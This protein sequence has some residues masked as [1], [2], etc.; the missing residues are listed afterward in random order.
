[1]NNKLFDKRITVSLIMQFIENMYAVTTLCEQPFVFHLI[2]TTLHDSEYL[3]N[4]LATTKQ[5]TTPNTLEVT[6]Q[7]CAKNH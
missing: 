7:Q 2:L 5:R 3:N 1:M 4:P 6:T